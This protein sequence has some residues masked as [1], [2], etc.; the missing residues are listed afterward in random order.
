MPENL[1][2]KNTTGVDTSKF[3]KKADLVSLRSDTDRLDIGKLKTVSV[4][5]YKLNNVVEKEAF[6]KTVYDEL[7]QKMNAIDTL[8]KKDYDALKLVILKVN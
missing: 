5:S 6:K 7:L 8:V 2:W 4:G 3:T 1:T